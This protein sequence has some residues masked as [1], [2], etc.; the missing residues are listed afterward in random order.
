MYDLTLREILCADDFSRSII[1]NLCPNH[2]QLQK[3]WDLPRI[4][5]DFKSL[6]SSASTDRD[7]ARLLA[8]Q[9][10][11]SGSWLQ[12]LPI[13]SLGLRMSDETFRIAAGLRLDA[14]LCQP[15][16]CVCGVQ[17]GKSGTHGLSCNKSAGRH[18]RH[19]VV[20]EIICKALTAS[21]KRTGWHSA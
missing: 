9:S 18:S 14:T 5:A 13:S 10:P 12:A 20:N 4:S 15:H 21:N 16:V 3:M 7:I 8:S 19:S 2:R 11:H 6:L 1:N 17:V